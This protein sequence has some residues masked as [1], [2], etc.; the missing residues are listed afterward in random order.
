MKRCR[1]FTL[2][3]LLV[4]IAI[5]SI[6]ASILLPALSKAREKGKR[7]VCLSNL[8]QIGVSLH[9]YAQEY[10]EWF[11]NAGTGENTDNLHPLYDYGYMESFDI[12][13]CPS[14]RHTVLDSTGLTRTYPTND[15]NAMSYRY[16][17]GMKETG[18]ANIALIWDS[19]PSNHQYDGVNC[20]YVGND[21]RWCPRGDTLK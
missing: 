2:I 10:G 9:I 19:Q 11:V 13:E 7:T 14:T 20:L 15:T 1:A 5:M 21:A 17:K 3:E 16:I 4:V 12:F 8:K 18:D 6:M